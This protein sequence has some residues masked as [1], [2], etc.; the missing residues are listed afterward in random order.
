MP[1]LWLAV[2]IIKGFD[3]VSSF[4]M[5]ILRFKFQECSVYMHRNIP[6]APGDQKK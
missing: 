1:W 6:C 5:I 2:L 4:K 3:P